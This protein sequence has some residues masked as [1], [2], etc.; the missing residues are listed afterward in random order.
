MR[1]LYGLSTVLVV[2]WLTTAL[3]TLSQLGVGAA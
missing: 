2:A 1:I 3:A